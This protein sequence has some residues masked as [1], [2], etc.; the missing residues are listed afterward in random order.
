MGWAFPKLA[1]EFLKARSGPGRTGVK[2]LDGLSVN[3]SPVQINSQANQENGAVAKESSSRDHH[4]G[5][6]VI[7]CFK[8]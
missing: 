7:R 2:R 5:A 8:A 6:Q 1:C 4:G 3:G